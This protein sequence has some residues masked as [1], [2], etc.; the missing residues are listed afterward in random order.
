[1]FDAVHL[2]SEIMTELN[3]FAYMQLLNPVQKI[4]EI[5]GANF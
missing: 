1:L 3:F 5:S 2:K 4:K